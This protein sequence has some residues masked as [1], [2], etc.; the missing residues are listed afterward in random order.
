MNILFTSIGRRRYLLEYF[1]EA[2]SGTGRI[3]ASNTVATHSFASADTGLISPPIAD[4]GYL[5]FIRDTCTQYDIDM[6]IPLLDVDVAV[7]SRNRKIFDEMNV[8]LLGPPENRSEVCWDKYIGFQHLQ[9]M[10]FPVPLS[11]VD[12]A[13]VSAALAAGELAYPLMLKPRKG[14]GSAGVILVRDASE[15][16]YHYPR[17]VRTINEWSFYPDGEIQPGAEVMI[18]QAVVGTEYGLDILGDLNGQPLVVV[19][20]EKLNQRGGETESATIIADPHLE[21]LGMRLAE[22]VG[23]CGNLDVD[24]IK[25]DSGYSV[26]DLNCRFGGQYPFAH[27]S[28]VN[29]PRVLIDLFNGHA[30][31][32]Q[33]L[34]FSVNL[35]GVKELTPRV[36]EY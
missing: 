35:M 36:M 30:P 20:K 5:Q 12:T 7:L 4:P 21:D 18:Q 11:F 8:V 6:V 1:R 13:E 17:L 9:Q 2:L 31:D 24:I 16:E 19:P 26:L 25:H 27:L 10:N 14:M 29:F 15:F 28:G 23:H 22:M 32:P 34:K 3:I 33:D